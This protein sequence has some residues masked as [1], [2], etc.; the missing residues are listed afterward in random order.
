L[1]IDLIAI[2]RLDWI[3]LG[4][5]ILFEQIRINYFGGIRREKRRKEW[6]FR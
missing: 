3:G 1:I 4:Y 2:D 5:F 6:I